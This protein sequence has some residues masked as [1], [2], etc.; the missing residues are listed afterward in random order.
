M[1]KSLVAVALLGAFAG[2][3][4]AQTAVQIYGNI[5][6]GLVKRTDATLA[7]G[8]RASNTLGFKGTEDLGNG[9]KA[10]FQIEMRYEPDTGTVE[11]NTRP[12]FQGQSRVGLQGDFGMIRLGRGLTPFQEVVGSFEPWH[13]LPSQAGFYTDISIAGFNSTP[14]DQGSTAA[15]AGQSNNRFSNAVFYNSPVLSGFQVNAAWASKEAI[16]G[17]AA[18]NNGTVVGVDYF[19]GTRYASGAAPTVNPFSVAATYN[20]G[21]AAAMLAYERN[22]VESKV[23]SIAGSFAVTPELKLMGTYS[24]QSQEHTNTQRPVIKGAVLGATYAMGPGKVLAGFGI[25][26]QE[27][28]VRLHDLFTRQ[29]SLGYEYSLSKRT[30]VYVDA[31]RKKNIVSQSTGNLAGTPTVNHFD[32][33]VNHSF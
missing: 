26:Q 11:N 25:K 33:G 3:A 5:D 30:Y 23:W 32:V 2:V 4:Q 15:G 6:A 13:G 12:L 1:K 24:R 27:E 10:L 20:N 22:A 8:K 9:L 21:P 17:G 14:L 18:V 7:I 28:N 16:S 29:Y 19:G 31:S